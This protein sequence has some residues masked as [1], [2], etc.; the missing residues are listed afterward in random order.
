MVRRAILDATRRVFGEVGYHGLS[1][2]LVLAEAGLSRPTFY[3]YFASMVEVV[4]LVLREANE[5]LIESILGAVGEAETPVSKLEAGLLAW[6]EWG[7]RV[8]PALRPFFAELH[9]RH[10]PVS[11]Y[12]EHTMKTLAASF[13]REA[14]ALGRPRPS[15]L[16]LD[17]VMLGIEYLGYKFHLDSA[18]DEKS[19][20]ITRDAM[21]RLAVGLLTTESELAHAVPL[22]HALAVN[23]TPEARD[24]ARAEEKDSDARAPTRERKADARAPT[25]ERNKDRKK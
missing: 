4:E 2:E 19:W 9:D 21:L 20:K 5:D 23:V 8:G 3:K 1:V 11:R 15:A 12:R 22:L 18:G 25:R 10:S 7:R 17:T 13:V 16:V 6:R 24:S 14:E